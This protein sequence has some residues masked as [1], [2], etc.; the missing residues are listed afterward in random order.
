MKAVPNDYQ[1]ANR[2]TPIAPDDLRLALS[3]PTFFLSNYQQIANKSRELVPM[4]PNAFQRRLFSTVLPLVDKQ[5]RLDER[6]TV[7]VVK[8]RQVGASVATTALIN[9]IC[10]YVTGM[11]NLHIAHTFPVTDTISKF[12]QQKVLP[13]IGGVHPSLFS[14]MVTER[15]GSSILTHYRDVKGIRRNNTYELVSANADSIRSATVHILIEDEV[16]YYRNPEDLDNAIMPALPDDGFSL[17]LY[18]STVS[19]KPD[20]FFHDKLRTALDNPETHT[21]VFVPWYC[22]YPEKHKNIDY[23]TLYPLSQYERDVIIPALTKDGFTEEQWGDYID[24]YRKKAAV[25]P[26]MKAEYPTIIEEVL[27]AGSDRRVFP[28]ELVAAQRSTAVTGRPYELVTT[29]GDSTPKAVLA[30]RSPFKIYRQPQYGHRYR[31]A[32]D[33]IT[34]NS[35]SSDFFTMSVH[36][37]SDH[38]QCATFR[39][40]NMPMEDYVDFALVIARLYNNAEL[41]PESNMAQAFV[42]LVNSQRYYHWY[43]QSQTARANRV[44]GVRTSATT[45]GEMIDRLKVLMKNNRIQINDPVWLDE[46][47]YFYKKESSTGKVTMAAKKGK[48]DDGIASLWIYAG[49]LTASQ[50]TGNMGNGWTIL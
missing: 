16:G 24:W 28:K 46:L 9:Y 19:D 44:P 50:A 40:R 29:L 27:E 2:T 32:I 11:E 45:K 14:N 3:D 4:V 22:T 36:D 35:S 34:S 18:L 48:T 15:L 20:S 42:E 41:C 31:I 43:Y 38:F 17:V 12:Y 1:L 49:S 8:S 23:H 7:V 6:H 10:A 13:I 39:G 30:D 33:P 26:A 21:V 25:V 5:T 47:D 37:L